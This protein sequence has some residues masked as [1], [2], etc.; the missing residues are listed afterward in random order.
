MATDITRR[1]PE[2]ATLRALGYRKGFLTR[3]VYAQGTLLAL[4]GYVPGLLMTLVG[5]EMARYEARI[6]IG[7]TGWRLVLVLGL[8]VGMCL[9]SS[10]VAV[11]I[12]Q[13]ADPADLF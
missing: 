10:L 4:I 11:R 3:A 1:L 6:P 5:Y 13:R 9:L 7:M 8:T 12:V 2:Y